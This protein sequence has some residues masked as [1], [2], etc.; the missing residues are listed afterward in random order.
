[1][2]GRLAMA[3]GTL[4]AFIVFCGAPAS[5]QNRHA[6]VVGVDAYRNVPKLSRAVADA[7]SMSAML[8]SLGFKTRFI[9]NP[10]RTTMSVE[11]AGFEESLEKGDTAFVFFAGHGIEIAGQNVLLPADAP[12][13]GR[14]SSGI[15]RDAGFNTAILIERITARGAR[16]A[17]FVF[18]ACRD[19]PYAKA[20]NTRSIGA[21]RGLARTE[22]PEG[23]F[24]LMS[25]GQNQQALDSLNQPGKPNTDKSQNSV[26]TRVLLDELAKP[27]LTHIVLAKAVQTRVRDL[28]RSI[29]HVQVPAFYDQIIG[30]VVLSAGGQPQ[31][32]AGINATIS[33]AATPVQSAVPSIDLGARWHVREMSANGIVHEGVWTQT[34]QST[35]KA[36]WRVAGSRET[37]SDTIEMESQHGDAVTLYRAGLNGRYFGTISDDGRLI[38]GHASWYGA[39]DRW[40]AEIHKVTAPAA[41]KPQAV[42]EIKTP[43][44]PLLDPGPRWHVRE[45]A[46]GGGVYEGVWTRTG[47]RSFKAEWRAVGSGD[48]ISDTIELKNQYGNVVV[49]YRVSIKGQYFGTISRDGR[50]IQGHA[51]WYS[52]G[53]R[54]SAEIR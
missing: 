42:G 49:L 34:G 21:A 16:S 47:P 39:G 26:F 48:T 13:P 1:M 40:A 15:L 29:D 22:A 7:R 25:A 53:D 30:D 20:G 51:S 52:A 23:V 32:N 38:W 35:F 45:V 9:E 6:L 46:A 8:Q 44:A 18:D 37:I 27:G 10:D 5:A 41:A 14:A 11:L 43:A 19:N 17:F 28:A 24:V 54:W 3:A 4:L 36:E 12:D 31:P 33:A 2:I 50:F